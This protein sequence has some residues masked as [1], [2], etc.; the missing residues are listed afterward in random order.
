MKTA[1]CP[2]SFDPITIGHLDI[3][4]RAAGLFD[5]VIVLIAV[6]P[7]KQTSFT[8]KERLVMIEKATAGMDNVYV[9][10]YGG[11][12]AEY[13]KEHGAS[14]IVKGLRA[15]TDF[16]YEFQMALANK[17]IY[18]DAET[19]FLT[20]NSE[21]MFLSSSVVKEIARY[22]GDIGGF[23]PEMLIGEIKER[24]ADKK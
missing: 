3:I 20:T 14:A 4:K 12:I 22:N 9:D 5:K 23:V 2:G 6:N 17:K 13:A 10:C 21:N 19:I 8:V 16:E 24:L 11:L 1:I 15:V 7:N 18:P